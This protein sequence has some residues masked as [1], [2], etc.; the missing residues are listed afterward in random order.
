MFEGFAPLDDSLG[1][2]G[3]GINEW[4]SDGG[5]EQDIGIRF[6]K[7]LKKN[8]IFHKYCCGVWQ[9]CDEELREDSV[10][11]VGKAISRVSKVKESNILLRISM[12]GEWESVIGR[13][14]V[15][16]EV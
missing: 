10:G 4:D 7:L 1:R 9:V 14:T 2:C 6:T 15:Y 8:K 12:P 11:D 3:N 13:G 16:G 5:Y